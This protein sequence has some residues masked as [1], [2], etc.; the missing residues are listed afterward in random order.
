[1]RQLREKGGGPGEVRFGMKWSRLSSAWICCK[2][3]RKYRRDA[4]RWEGERR[5]SERNPKT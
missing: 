4:E 2:D 5:T 3:G 1:L